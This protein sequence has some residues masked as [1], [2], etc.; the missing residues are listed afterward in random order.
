MDAQE[1]EIPLSCW[2]M[3]RKRLVTP[4]SDTGELSCCELNTIV[5]GHEI[6]KGWIP[7]RVTAWLSRNFKRRFKENI[8]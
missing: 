1:K 5:E 2:A 6:Q 3:G 8:P 4:L 7:Y